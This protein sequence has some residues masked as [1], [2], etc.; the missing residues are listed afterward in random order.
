MFAARSNNVVAWNSSYCDDCCCGGSCCCSVGL[1]SSCGGGGGA[2]GGDSGCLRR[3][4][5]RGRWKMAVAGRT[6]L[7]L[8]EPRYTGWSRT[9]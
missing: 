6:H 5:G 3:Q 9:N 1:S 4:E 2:G 8:P 7:P